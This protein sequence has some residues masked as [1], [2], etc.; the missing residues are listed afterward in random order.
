MAA[1][2]KAVSAIQKAL[3]RSLE[4]RIYG[5]C[6]Y[7][8]RGFEGE[9]PS[10]SLPVSWTNLRAWRWLCVDIDAPNNYFRVAGNVHD[11]HIFSG[12]V[13]ASGIPHFYFHVAV[14]GVEFF[15]AFDELDDAHNSVLVGFPRFNQFIGFV[16]C[17]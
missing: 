2:R 10:S 1:D 13:I 3:W 7:L 16:V 4:V 9:S 12:V 6:F 5:T 17:F 8:W 15:E 14:F 11:L